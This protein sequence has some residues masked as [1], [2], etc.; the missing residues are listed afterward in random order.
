MTLSIRTNL[1]SLDAQRN[2]S[3]A[4][5][6]LESSMAR[7]SS[8]Y[9]ITKA[10]DDAAGLGISTKLE[11]QIRSYNQAVRNANDGV[12]VVQTTEAGLNQSANILTRLRE[13]AMQ[14]ASDG[15]GDSER[16][17][18]DT[19]AQQLL[20]ELDRIAQTTQ[21]NGVKLL[22][23]SAVT[24]DFHVGIE[25]TSNDIVSLTTLDATVLTTGPGPMGTAAS[26][27]LTT[28]AANGYSDSAAQ[29]AALAAA[30]AVTNPTAA[31]EAAGAAHEIFL[32]GIFMAGGGSFSDPVTVPAEQVAGSNLVAATQ[33]GGTGGNALLSAAY[34]AFSAAISGGQDL[35]SAQSAAYG[36]AA[37]AAIAG[38]MSVSNA[39]SAAVAAG[40]AALHVFQGAYSTVTG[41]ATPST[42]PAGAARTAGLAALAGTYPGSS[43][44]GGLGV[45]G[46]SLASKTSAVAAL[47]T[48]D[49]ALDRVSSSRSILGA[50]GNR[51]QAA[52]TNIQAA[53]ESM[54][55][56][57]SRIKDVDVAE[58]TSQLARNQILS[59]AAT[60]VIAQANQ[61]PQLALKLFG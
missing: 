36:A 55:A 45:A 38:G 58:E 28:M 30:A 33:N 18:I 39:P 29:P 10:G 57:N 14:S 1:A 48:V 24:L 61:Q 8:G 25:A 35:A 22:D 26:T 47:G 6:T 56:A 31:Q 7:L 3:S 46:L 41:G 21:F 9:R 51:L 2:L 60:S 34:G 27:Y 44:A 50:A 4:Q 43:S 42:P 52:I 54:A 49:A 11:S 53:S 17:Y 32:V 20:S 12:S 15:I 37:A 59:Q 16:A 23:G 40:T 13:L 5:S 19:E